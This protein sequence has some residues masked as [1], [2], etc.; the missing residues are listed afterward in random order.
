M[1]NFNDLLRHYQKNER[2]KPLQNGS[3]HL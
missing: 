3:R 1:K 2:E